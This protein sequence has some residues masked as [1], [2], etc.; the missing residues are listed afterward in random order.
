MRSARGAR[1]LDG[2]RWPGGPRWPYAAGAALLGGVLAGGAV[3][4]RARLLLV[5]VSGPS[6]APAYRDGQRLLA[7]RT[8][9]ARLRTG[10]VVVFR[11][12]GARPGDPLMV[13]RVAALPGEPVPESVRWATGTVA[14]DVVPPARLVVL[15]DTPEVSADSRSWGYVEAAAVVGVVVRALGD[16][17]PPPP[18]ASG[19]TAPPP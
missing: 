9:P 6:M 19:D 17:A 16:T 3:L 13:K 5:T 8:S 15:G 11:G 1:A 10:N 12:P 4:A 2:T 18:R 14:G 7:V